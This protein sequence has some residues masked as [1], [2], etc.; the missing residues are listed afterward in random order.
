MKRAIVVGG[1]GFVGSALVE[2][3]LAH[4]V[5]VCAVVKPGFWKS[6]EA[7][8]LRGLH[9]LVAECDLREIRQLKGLFHSLATELCRRQV[10]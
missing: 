2:V 3:L 7:F 6:G 9:A 4:G 8:R 10:G 5:E 1:G